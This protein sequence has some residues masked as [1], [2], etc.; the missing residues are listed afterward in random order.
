MSE[1]E[2]IWISRD[3]ARCSGCRRCEIVCSLSHEGKIWPE[4]SRIRVFMLVPSVEVPHL[5][6]QCNDYPCVAACPTNALSV[7]METEAVIVNK[8]RCVACGK[9]IEACPGKVPFIHPKENYAVICDLCGGD[10]KCVQVCR[11]GGWGALDI[12]RKD[13]SLSFKLY[14]KRPEEITRNLLIKLYGESLAEKIF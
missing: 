12:M 3:Y 8:E 10:P 5:C 2:H 4:A 14:A 13:D 6:A 11:E 9:C 1:K 7:N